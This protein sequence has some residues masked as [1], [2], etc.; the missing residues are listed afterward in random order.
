MDSALRVNAL[1]QGLPGVGM[2]GGGG[3]CSSDVGTGGTDLGAGGEGMAGRP[4]RPDS[5]E[6]T[7]KKI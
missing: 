3:L 7:W 5:Q 2:P 1:G 6:S 4:P